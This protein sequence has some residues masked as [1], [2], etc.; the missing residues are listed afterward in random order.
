MVLKEWE[1]PMKIVSPGCLNLVFKPA[2]KEILF[3]PKIAQ[4]LL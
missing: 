2:P 4:K 1:A 3:G